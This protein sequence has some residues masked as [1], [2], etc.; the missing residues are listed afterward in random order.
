MSF[1]YFG[2]CFHATPEVWARSHEPFGLKTPKRVKYVRKDSRNQ[3]PIEAPYVP[4]N[5]KAT[6][7]KPDKIV[8]IFEGMTLVELAKRSGKLVS[9][10][11]GILT[12]VGEKVES[13]FEPLSMDIAELVAM[14]FPLFLL[15]DNV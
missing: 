11:Q 10:L 14:V 4:P 13:E 1:V 9:F 2:R 6:K 15:T 7:S 3:P 5:V 8:E 12:N